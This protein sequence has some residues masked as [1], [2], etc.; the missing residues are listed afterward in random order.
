MLV[1][2]EQT[3]LMIRVVRLSA[4][5]YLDVV[6]KRLVVRYALGPEK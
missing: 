2:L 4:V 1:E 3:P 5:V 6:S